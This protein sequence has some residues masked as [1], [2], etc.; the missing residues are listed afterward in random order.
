[1]LNLC[2]G[3]GAIAVT[4]AAERPLATVVATDLSDAALAVAARNAKRHGVQERVHFHPG[5]LYA[6]VPANERFDLIAANPP[7]ITDAAYATLAQDITAHEP[8][9]A[10][11]SG[12]D[13]LDVCAGS[14]P[15]PK[16]GSFRAERCSS[17][18]ATIRPKPCRRCSGH[19]RASSM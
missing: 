11:T 14:V 4:L 19:A 1:M 15:R 9:L 3:S 5:D 8:R 12:A 6:A 17:R 18:S 10:L 7:Y 13:G 2:T 16:R